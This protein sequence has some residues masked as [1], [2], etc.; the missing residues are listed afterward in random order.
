MLNIVP[1]NEEHIESIYKI[2]KESFSDPWKFE[3]FSGL[4]ENNIA[5]CFTAFDNDEIVGFLISY[6]IASEIEILNIAVKQSKRRQNIAVKLFGAVFDYAK[7]NDIDEFFLEVRMSN[8]GAIGLYKKLGF[9]ING[10]RKNYYKNP[11]EDAIL[12]SLS[13]RLR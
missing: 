7:N 3:M 2:E 1:L 5:V 6:H 13:L 11:T 12:M 9:E 8:T 10:I 4:S